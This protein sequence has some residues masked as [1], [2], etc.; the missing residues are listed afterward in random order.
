MINPIFKPLV[1]FAFPS[2]VFAMSCWIVA[3][4]LPIFVIGCGAASATSVPVMGTVTIDG[5]PVKSAKIKFISR[6]DEKLEAVAMVTDGNFE[7]TGVNGPIEGE[8]D[9]LIYYSPPDFEELQ[10]MI[11]QDRDKGMLSSDIPQ[12]YAQA[13]VLTATISA[14]KVE[15]MNFALT[16]DR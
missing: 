11:K 15:A 14:T 16:S 5:E 6:D 4:G 2:F 8:H 13:G 1:R 12:A 3:L 7:F 9:V 10:E